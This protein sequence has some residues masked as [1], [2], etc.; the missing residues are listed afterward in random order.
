MRNQGGFTLTEFTLSVVTSSV[1]GLLVVSAILG[2]QKASLA[3]TDGLN[4][5]AQFRLLRS[6][7]GNRQLMFI[8]A[9]AFPANSRFQSC[10]QTQT[11]TGSPSSPSC[12][13]GE[14]LGLHLLDATNEIV[15]GPDQDAY[16]Y[17]SGPQPVFYTLTGVRCPGLRQATRQCPMSA[18]AS[19]RAQGLPNLSAAPTATPAPGQRQEIVEVSFVISIDPIIGGQTYRD[20]RGSVVYDLNEVGLL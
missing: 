2:F 13:S 7:T 8:K 11:V 20:V 1:F 14:T 17:A 4:R 19:F 9:R 3:V 10:T 15:A 12:L 6:I 18:I 16:E 5:D